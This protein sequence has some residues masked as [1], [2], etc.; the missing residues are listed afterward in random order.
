M[1]KGKWIGAAVAL[2]VVAGG[3]AYMLS[4]NGGGKV[5]DVSKLSPVYDNKGT[6]IKGGNLNV[7]IQADVP[8]KFQWLSA[9]ALDAVMDTMSKPAGGLGALFY[10]D[11]D[12]H[13]KDNGPAK[14]SFDKDAKTATIT[15]KKNLKW[16]DGHDVT[17]KDYY[18]ANEI[19]AGPEYKSDRW[20]STLSNIEGMQEYHEGKTD[21]ISGIEMPDGENGKVV[22]IHFKENKPGFVQSGNGYFLEEVVP[23]HYLKDVAPKDLVSSERTTTKPLVIGPFVPDKVVVGESIHYV[24]NKYFFGKKPNLDS[25]TFSTVQSSKVVASLKAGKYDT[26]FETGN[27]LFKQIAGLKNYHVLGRDALYISN[28]YFNLGHYDAEKQTNVQDRETPLQDANVRRAMGYARNVAEV[29]KKFGNG[30]S[31]RATTVVPPIFKEYHDNKLKGFPQELEEANKLLDKAGYKWDSKKEYREKDGKRLSF[32]YLAR[33]GNADAE[34]IAQN[35]IQQWK[36]IGVEVKLYN[37]R[38]T[39]FNTWSDMMDDGSNDWDL[40]DG[41]W[42]LSSEPSQADLFGPDAQ[43]NFGHFK[44]E[45]LTKIM[46]NIDSEKSLNQTYRKQQFDA[47]QAYMNKQAYVIPTSYSKDYIPVNNRVKNFNFSY[48]NNTLWED[49][50]VTAKNP[51]K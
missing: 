17:A 26:V 9:Y 8:A 19:M 34:S 20:N 51:V 12:F 30:L 22:K 50:S 48:A 2:A 38:L 35:Y 49:L 29:A 18:F 10:V 41:A 25:I 21:K 11:K 31:S 47:Y 15:L 23:Y 5:Q 13:F 43:F 36:K 1:S 14:I 3:A 37:G 6:A 32:V 28:L 40:T 42:A 46:E 45:K 44:D 16:S 39:D 27:S 24:P 4:N 33:S 7:A